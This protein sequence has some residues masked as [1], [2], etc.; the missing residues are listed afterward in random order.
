MSG[1]IFKQI[2][3]P[4]ET[5]IA[6]QIQSEIINKINAEYPDVICMRLGSVGHKTTPSGDIDIGVKA[7]TVDDLYN[8][9]FNR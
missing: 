8:I 3:E 5:D 7:A 4:I 6:V 2:T 9:T 1:H